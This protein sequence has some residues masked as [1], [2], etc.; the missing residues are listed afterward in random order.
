MPVDSGGLWVL[1]EAETLGLLAGA[2][3]GRVVVSIN[4]MPAAFPVNY[5]LIG[6]QI[7]FRTAAGTKLSAAVN[8]TVVAFQV[9]E[10]DSLGATGWSVLVVGPAR[11]V[12]DAQETRLLDA[13]GL[14]SW[15]VAAGARY[16]AVAIDRIT[17]R[18]LGGMP[19]DAGPLR[20]GASR[21]P[22]V[23]SAG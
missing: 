9:D 2:R 13:A 11:V 15:G 17:G 1:S 6:R 19:R 16:V 5:A 3:V 8:R 22:A 20:A 18:R 10:F 4:A 21:G 14:Y 7:Y 12:G 23:P